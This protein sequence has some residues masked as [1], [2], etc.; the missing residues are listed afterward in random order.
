METCVD[1]CENDLSGR[2]D[3]TNCFIRRLG[4]CFH[5]S[6]ELFQNWHESS[7]TPWKQGK[8]RS[9]TFSYLN[10]GPITCVLVTSSNKFTVKD[11]GRAA[12]YLSLVLLLIPWKKFNFLVIR[13]C[14]LKTPREQNKIVKIFVI[15]CVPDEEV[16]KTRNIVRYKRFWIRIWWDAEIWVLY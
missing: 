12:P 4:E 10:K 11:W 7:I 3:H 15:S 5:S 8:K 14:I 13:M 2:L 6:F 9:Y 16:R 1:V